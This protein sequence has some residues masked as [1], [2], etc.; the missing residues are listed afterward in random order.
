MMNI[1]PSAQPLVSVIIPVYNDV[2]G[3]KTCLQALAHQSY[4]QSQIEIIVI[5][6]GSEDF[7]HIE[8]TV[9]P[10]QNVR[11]VQET[12]PGSYAARNKG[13]QI[14]KG[15]I[16]AFTDADCIPMQDWIEK[17]VSYLN[18]NDPCAM[19]VGSVEVFS[20]T[21][22]GPTLIELYQ[23]FLAFPQELHLKQFQAGATANVMVRRQVIDNVG[24]FDQKLKSFGDFEWGQRVFLAG[25]LQKYA[26]DVKVF[27]PARSN[28]QELKCRSIRVAG[29]FYDYY[30]S[31]EENSFRRFR[32]FL[33][34][35][36]QDLVPPVNFALKTLREPKLRSLKERI[37]LPGI[38]LL[39]RYMSAVEKTRLWLGGTSARA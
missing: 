4:P 6:N 5:D 34:L 17:G 25:Y 3:L 1:S 9:H 18:D 38:L 24:K 30:V 35:V 36:L 27:H 10:Y 2:Q 26:E 13:I 33:K 20:T 28:W 32:K 21:P 16:I 31:M 11:L 23:M 12:E 14:A 37:G 15:S 29:G 39:V 7:P 22:T 19:L 8:S